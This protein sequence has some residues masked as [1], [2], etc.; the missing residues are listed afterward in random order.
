MSAGSRARASAKRAVCFVLYRLLTGRAV[1][2]HQ[3]AEYDIA[4]LFATAIALTGAKVTAKGMPRRSEHDHT[5]PGGEFGR[6][7]TTETAEVAVDLDEGVLNQVGIV[8]PLGDSASPQCADEEPDIRPIAVEQLSKGFGVART[9][10]IKGRL[11]VDR[12]HRPPSCCPKQS[13][14][15][16][17]FPKYTPGGRGRKETVTEIVRWKAQME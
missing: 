1:G 10:P 9:C 7:G 16:K 5:Q 4:R 15:Y 17:D 8:E 2:N 13:K 3:P 14:C 12:S 6:H 11:L